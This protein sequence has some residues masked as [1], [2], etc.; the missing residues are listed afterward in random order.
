MVSRYCRLKLILLISLILRQLHDTPG[1][2]EVTLTRQVNDEK[3]VS[4][5]SV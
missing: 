4:Y 2:E 5:C 3:Y 1:I